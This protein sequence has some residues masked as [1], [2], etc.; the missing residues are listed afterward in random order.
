MTDQPI[1]R[2]RFAG[3]QATV[4]AGRRINDLLA[5]ARDVAGLTAPDEPLV[6]SGRDR[7][8]AAMLLP[9]HADPSGVLA[10]II[11]ELHTAQSHERNGDHNARDLDEAEE[12]RAAAAELARDAVL[13]DIRTVTS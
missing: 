2:P 1:H 7:I 11:G 3:D 10:A 9:D 6:L 4:P 5:Y 13:T 8:T 12:H